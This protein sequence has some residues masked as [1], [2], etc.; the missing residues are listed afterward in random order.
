MA[1]F[2][3][4]ELEGI[5]YVDC[6][7][8]KETVRA[9][10]SALSYMTGDIKMHSHLVASP[11]NV[12]KSILADEAVYR[13]TYTGTGVV[14]LKSS[15]GGF[16]LLDLHDERWILERGAYWACEGRVGVGYHRV[17]I[18]TSRWAGEGLV[19]LQT[20]VSGSGKVVLTTRG[21]VER[22]TLEKASG[23]SPMAVTSSRGPP[24]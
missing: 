9:G 13:P 20:E 7:L 2:E 16:H 8:N 10:A 22:L 12:I 1:E 23:S 19:Y 17:G 21:P 3:I 4:H 14:P 6:I 24:A 18:L 15:L 11:S 5:R